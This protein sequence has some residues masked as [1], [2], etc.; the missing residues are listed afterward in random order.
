MKT[1]LRYLTVIFAVMFLSGAVAMAQVESGVIAGTVTDQ[2][3]AII[4]GANVMVRNLDNNAE[5]TTHTSSTG[6]FNVPGLEPAKY[7]ITIT[8]GNFKP[9]TANV[10]VTVGGHVSIDAKLSVSAGTT[11]VQVVAEG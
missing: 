1:L 6:A 7:V 8:S 2:S 11:E 5:R 3:G 9:Y 4:G 10:E